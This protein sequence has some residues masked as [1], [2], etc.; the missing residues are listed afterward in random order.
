MT[1]TSALQAL[2]FGPEYPWL[3]P[4]AGYTDLAFRLLCREQGAAVACTEM[5]S[6]KGLVLGQG[7]RSGA[8]EELLLTTPL[9]GEAPQAGE[10]NDQ[11]LVVQ[12]FGS[13]ASFLGEAVSRLVDRGY[14]WFDLNMGCSVPKVVKSGSGAAMARDLDNAAAVAKAM[15]AAAG[16]GRV[17]FKLRLGWQAGDEVFLDL[18]R[19]LE[20]AG[21]GW[22]T[23]HPR[24]ARQGFT[25]SADWSALAR[26]KTA[27]SLPVLASG[28]LF[29]AED[30]VRCLRECSV[31]GVMFARGA[32]SNPFVFRQYLDLLAGREPASPDPVALCALIRRHVALIRRYSTNRLNKQGIEAGLLKMRTFIPRYGKHVPGARALRAALIAMRDWNELESIL[33][34]FFLQPEP[35][36]NFTDAIT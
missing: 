32:M 31:D 3:A 7:R 18:A 36:K 12:L 15:I 6:A 17:G 16:P 21:A 28:D 25:G 8:T 9:P 23:L 19:E 30:A 4:L 1:S 2:P 34:S 26:L 14:R 33:E 5:V 22:L 11:P 24:F 29:T 27:V 35:V 10:D 20:M 13:E